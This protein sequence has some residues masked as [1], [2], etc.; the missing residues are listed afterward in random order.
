MTET[1]RY[2]LGSGD[3]F[4]RLLRIA[5]ANDGRRL[6]A[7]L[8]ASHMTVSNTELH[9]VDVSSWAELDADPATA[10][11]QQVA[12]GVLRGPNVAFDR[13]G[14]Y[15]VI[16]QSNGAEQWDLSTFGL[17]DLNTFTLTTQ[18]VPEGRV[19]GGIQRGPDILLL[20]ENSTQLQMFDPAAGTVTP[21]AATF[22][23]IDR[24]E[25]GAINADGTKLFIQTPSRLQVF[26]PFTGAVLDSFSNGPQYTHIISLTP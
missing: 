24:M 9:V 18:T 7:V 11:V 23:P 21:M 26:D 4:R 6:A 17:L 20:N 1:S 14:R 13:S 8:G 15:L 16:G 19:I 10:G 5:L 25:C 3:G 22:A 12:L 2:P